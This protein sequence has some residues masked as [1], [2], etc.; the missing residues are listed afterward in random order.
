MIE[1]NVVDRTVPWFYSASQSQMFNRLFYADIVSNA[2]RLPNGNTLICS[3]V[4]GRLFE[5]TTSGRI[6]WEYMSPFVG[7]ATGGPSS[8]GPGASPRAGPRATSSKTPTPPRRALA[9]PLPP[10]PSN[11][12]RFPLTSN[13]HPHSHEVPVAAAGRSQARTGP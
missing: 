13:A 4:R 8:T 1:I 12:P 9:R 6:V 7:T 2:E 5:V 3:G 10:L 11:L